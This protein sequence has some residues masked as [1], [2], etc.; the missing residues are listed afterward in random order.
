MQGYQRYIFTSRNQKLLRNEIESIV[1]IYEIALPLPIQSVSLG[2]NDIKIVEFGYVSCEN[3]SEI[4]IKVCGKMGSYD[5]D[6]RRGDFG[7]SSIIGFE[8]DV[9]QSDE[10]T[11]Q[12]F[13]FRMEAFV[14]KHLT[15]KIAIIDIPF[16]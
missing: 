2:Q 1:K 15:D 4:K 13:N 12:L 9:P 10:V 14:G 7:L 6:G 11:N 3:K 8:V 16:F 5:L